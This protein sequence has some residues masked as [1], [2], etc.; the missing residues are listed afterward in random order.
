MKEADRRPYAHT[1][2]MLVLAVSNSPMQVLVSE[3]GAMRANGKAEQEQGAEIVSVPELRR[4]SGQRN[5][6]PSSRVSS[7]FFYG[8]WS[9][10][11]LNRQQSEEPVVGVM[12]SW[13]G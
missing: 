2:S 7:S 1:L 5:C 10:Q 12:S 13:V 4:Y 9:P 8:V 11:N 3:P 6:E